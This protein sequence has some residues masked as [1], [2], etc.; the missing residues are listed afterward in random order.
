[1]EI[2]IEGVGH[3]YGGLTALEDIHLTVREGEILALVG[4]SGCGKS[5]LLN[6]VGGLLVPTRYHTGREDSI[7]ADHFPL[8]WLKIW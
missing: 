8:F 2:R 1:M 7:R 5:T 4:P 6:I 3:R